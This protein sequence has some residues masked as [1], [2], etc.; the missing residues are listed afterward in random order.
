M[1]RFLIKGIL[2]DKR[3]SIL[4]IVVVSIGVALT[5][6]LSGYIRGAF[7]DVTDQNARFDTGHV[8]VM[9]RAYAAYVDQLPN[10][11]ALLEVEALVAQLKR[12][13]P[14]MDWVRRIKFGGL[15]DVPGE[16]G[17]SK[18][19]GPA[20]GIAIDLLHPG[21]GE[22]ER[23]NISSS[24][25]E[26]KVPVR[27]GEALIGH[28]FAKKLG[29]GIGDELTFFGS[30][31]NG[32]MTFRNFTVSGTIRF[33]VAVMDRGAL[34]IDV[35]DAQQMLDMEDGAGEVLGY[36]KTNAYDN[37]KAEAISG[38]FIAQ[39]AAD[40]DEFA[41]TMLPLKQQNNLAEL[42]DYA[43]VMSGIFVLVFVLAMSVVLWNMGLQGGLR[44]YREFGIRLALGESKG[45]IYRSL[46]TE[47]ILV[48]II[49]SLVGTAVGG[50]G[51]WLL[52][53]YGID[54]SGY[55]ENSSMLMPAVIRAKV[56]PELLYLGFIPGVF[57]IVLGTM[58]SGIGIYKRQTARLFKELEV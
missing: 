43:D 14:E 53:V 35:R 13:F 27:Q 17:G 1:I 31:M 4:P 2:R 23:M 34:I 25:V 51:A 5:V 7:D 26:G 30:T 49:G 11:L 46:I 36:F 9:T 54:I 56:T 18:G 48:G 52:Q 3:R 39:Y 16:N 42:L 28:H 38:R 44:R 8:K 10:D 22:L 58:L 57:A 19:Q 45:H 47:A 15:I 55:M 40:K 21:S 12:D 33:G 32:S 37:E 50:A 41:P 24:L 29:L 6:F 20:S